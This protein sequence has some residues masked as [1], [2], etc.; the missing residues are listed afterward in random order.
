MLSFC[1]P[2]NLV[3]GHRFDP[4]RPPATCLAITWTSACPDAELSAVLRLSSGSS[5]YSTPVITDLFSDANKDVVLSTFVRYLDGT[6]KR[7]DIHT[8]ALSPPDSLPSL[9]LKTPPFASD[10]QCWKGWMVTTSLA[11]LSP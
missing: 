8:R 3:S 7:L 11:G 5:I 6:A 9:S 1:G 10:S 4:S 2:L